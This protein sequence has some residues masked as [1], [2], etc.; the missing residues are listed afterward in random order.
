MAVT[1]QLPADVEERPRAESPDLDC[2]AKEAM[3]VELYRQ[4]RLS[5]YELSQAL[6]LDRF[7]ADAVLKKH[8]VTVDL[9]TVEEIEEDLRR[10]RQLA[11]PG[12]SIGG[13]VTVVSDASLLIIW[14][15]STRSRFFPS[16]FRTSMF[17]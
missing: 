3:L 15:S 2:E 7:E 11:R 17:R 8:N 6:G 13:A 14:S 1:I 9:P 4:D 16:H 12:R 5:H 10:L